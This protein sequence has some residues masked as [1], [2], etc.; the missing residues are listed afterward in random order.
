MPSLEF[1][2]LLAR[3]LTPAEM[4]RRALREGARFN[5]ATFKKETA[6]PKAAAEHRGIKSVEARKKTE[7][8]F[9]LSGEFDIHNQQEL[10]LALETGMAHKTVTVD[11]A[12]TSFVDASILGTLAVFASARLERRASRVRILNAS[13]HLLKLFRLCRLETVFEFGVQAAPRRRKRA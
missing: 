13:D 8:R 2:G 9:A 3:I 6:T 5:G 11:L 1:A 10:A 4:E 12:Q 7:M